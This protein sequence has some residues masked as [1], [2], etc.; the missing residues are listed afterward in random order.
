L[1]LDHTAACSST[2]Y[3]LPGAA[4]KTC[5]SRAP[6][7]AAQDG[8]PEQGCCWVSVQAAAVIGETPQWG[9]VNARALRQGKA[10]E[11]V[12]REQEAELRR[13]S[14][15]SA[16]EDAEE[17]AARDRQRRL[18]FRERVLQLRRAKLVRCSVPSTVPLCWRGGRRSTWR[19][20]AG[21]PGSRALPALWAVLCGPICYQTN[22]LIVVSGEA[23]FFTFQRLQWLPCAGLGL[24]RMVVVMGCLVALCNTF[25]G[26]HEHGARSGRRRCARGGQTRRRA[27]AC[28]QAQPGARGCQRRSGWRT[29]A[30]CCATLWSRSGGGASAGCCWSRYSR[31][32]SPARSTRT[33]RSCPEKHRARVGGRAVSEALMIFI[34]CL[35]LS[36]STMC[37]TAI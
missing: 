33:T 19:A 4:R 37:C 36:R 6:A 13:V 34:T 15:L 11:P 12:L 27:P 9:A 32:G 24:L 26:A 1:L 8:S 10:R 3:E 30:S 20:L 28:A 14:A 25:G 7:R 18:R 2:E 22:R 29:S 16:A 17:A 5:R 31:S 21:V 23:L 35:R